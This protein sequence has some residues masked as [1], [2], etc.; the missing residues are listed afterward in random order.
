MTQEGKAFCAE[1]LCLSCINRLESHSHREATTSL[2]SQ[3]NRC[4]SVDILV[5]K[6]EA[7]WP[8]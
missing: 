5:L 2:V 3:K 7:F 1:R 6:D 8:I 4:F